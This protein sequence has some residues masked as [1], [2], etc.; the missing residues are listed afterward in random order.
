M[1][2]RNLDSETV[3]NILFEHRLLGASYRQE[4]SGVAFR[5]RPLTSDGQYAR[6]SPSGRRG[7]WACYHGFRD[8]G[9]AILSAGGTFRTVG[10]TQD[11]RRVTYKT[12]DQFEGDL[13]AFARMNIGSHANPACMVDL[14]E[15]CEGALDRAI[16]RSG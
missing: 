6:R 5:L 2:V 16:R 3:E 7:P 14:C 12:E 10:P 9:R 11:R 8:F 4:G 13:D 15:C 1:I